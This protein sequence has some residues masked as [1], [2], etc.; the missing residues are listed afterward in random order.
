M[1]PPVRCGGISPVAT[2]DHGAGPETGFYRNPWPVV[3]TVVSGRELS[4]LTRIVQEIDRWKKPNTRGYQKLLTRVVRAN[5]FPSTHSPSKNIS[6]LKQ[7]TKV[8]TGIPQSCRATRARPV[9]PGGAVR[10][11]AGDGVHPGA[12]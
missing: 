3:L 4:R 12:G 11:F 7:A 8:S 2:G 1:R 10:H 6:G 9:L 5:R